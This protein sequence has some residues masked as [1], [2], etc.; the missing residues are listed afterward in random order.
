MM[1]HYMGA[2]EAGTDHGWIVREVR[3]DAF[4]LAGTRAELCCSKNVKDED[5][6]LAAV[7]QADMHAETS[8]FPLVT[9]EVCCRRCL[10]LEGR[11]WTFYVWFEL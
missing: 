7:V 8:M 2:G 5:W 6:I 11:L 9:L 4:E 3:Q 10:R 1:V